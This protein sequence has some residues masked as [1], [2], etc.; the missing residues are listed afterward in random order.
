M[1]PCAESFEYLRQKMV[2]EQL[3]GR[4]IKDKK[5]LDAFKKIPRHNFVDPVMYKDAY[6][7][8]PLSIGKGQTI[9]QPYI[10]ALM[11]QLLDLV[12]TD[13]VLEIGTGS[14][15]E[16]AILAELAGEVFSI[17]RIDALAVKAEE[18]LKD[19]GCKNVHTK[20]GDGTLG[21]QEFAPFDKIIVTASSQD[22]PEPLLNQLS[23]GGKL[24]IP[25]GSRF[26]QRL[27]VLEKDKE[28]RIFER[29]VCGCVFVPL[30]GKYGY[31]GE[32]T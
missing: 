12:K 13:K 1:S 21:W 30:I 20:I 3:L 32:N 5:V 29:D 7:D 19:L 28:G 23:E 26:T 2:A 31:A 4:D 22:I 25:V 24:T 18:V 27:L 11:V 17:E 6:G 8:F 14:A 16:T 9:S 10:V 15:Y